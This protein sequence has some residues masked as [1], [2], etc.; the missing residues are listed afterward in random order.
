MKQH[1]TGTKF[2]GIVSHINYRE[3]GKWDIG[4]AFDWNRVI[5]GVQADEFIPA[6]GE[7]RSR[8]A[9]GAAIQSEDDLEQVMPQAKDPSEQNEPYEEAT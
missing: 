6:T 7:F 8:G 4:H 1:Q 9:A 2:R 5:H 3:S